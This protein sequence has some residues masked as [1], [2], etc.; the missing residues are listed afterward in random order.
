MENERLQSPESPNFFEDRKPSKEPITIPT[1]RQTRKSNSIEAK[2]N[3]SESSN[4]HHRNFDVDAR[5]GR[6]IFNRNRS[7]N[8]FERDGSDSPRRNY[9]NPSRSRSRSRGRYVNRSRSRSRGRD[10]FHHRDRSR[11]WR[12]DRN[13]RRNDYRYN[14][15][16]GDRS[17]KFGNR[18][19][20]FV[21]KNRQTVFERL[22]HRVD[23]DRSDSES[24]E[25]KFNF[26]DVEKSNSI[27]AVTNLNKELLED[28]TQLKEQKAILG[29]IRK[30][31]EKNSQKEIIAKMLAEEQEEDEMEEEAKNERIALR[32]HPKPRVRSENEQAST[33]ASIPTPLPPAT[34]QS[35][36]NPWAPGDPRSFSNENS[37]FYNNVPSSFTSSYPAV[38]HRSQISSNIMSFHSYVP[39]IHMPY[40]HVP[41]HTNYQHNSI[42]PRPPNR[43]QTYAE[44]RREMETRVYRAPHQNINVPIVSHKVIQQNE[45]PSVVS[46]SAQ[47]T[48]TSPKESATAPD[49]EQPVEAEKSS[50]ENEQN[51]LAKL[52]GKQRISH[53][54]TKRGEKETSTTEKKSNSSTISSN[55]VST[56]TQKTVFDKA[57]STNDWGAL[58]A[59][60]EQSK[61]LSFKIPK[62]T[63]L[64]S[65][66]KESSATSLAKP[67]TD[68]LVPSTKPTKSNQSSKENH[69]TAPK[70]KPQ[71][72]KS[73]SARSF[74]MA[75]IRPTPKEPVE[76]KPTEAPATEMVAKFVTDL[77]SS[78]NSATALKKIENV[79]PQ[80]VLETI[81]TVIDKAKT[82][83]ADDSAV[84]SSTPTNEGEKST[85][86]IVEKPAPPKHVRNIAKKS[87]KPRSNE[88]S[89]LNEDINNMFI[90]NDLL[91]LT[92][93]RLCTL[94]KKENN[95]DAAPTTTAKTSEPK[96][97][98]VNGK[99]RK[100]EKK[101]VKKK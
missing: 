32:Y 24:S 7:R 14:E 42:G 1:E 75:T 48:I 9:R 72:R 12:D 46:S 3:V 54:N 43:K 11:H 91:T 6:Y 64:I 17:R 40:A 77:F 2:P 47:S 53:F 26:D 80:N 33:S 70:P 4:S 22:G 52:A 97:A 87:T 92:G 66:N 78:E 37:G 81:R 96:T 41:Q 73:C 93:K 10:S 71:R 44:H 51:A 99:I 13:D 61:K 28:V 18:K 23:S 76:P 65:T 85:E 20:S 49:Q 15:T 83:T 30:E 29:N 38:P 82:G 58:P 67:Q 100:T 35:H 45:S 86:E 21:P 50:L 39:P 19:A 31:E 36:P 68:E 8:R 27:A 90:R 5:N 84:S 88:L 55:T 79:V 69:Q 89:R 57:F 95:A 101:I 34:P 94:I 56:S 59:N 74:E 25:I 60:N 16:N 63:R 98:E 62:L